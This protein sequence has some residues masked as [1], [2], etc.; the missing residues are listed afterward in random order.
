MND[1]LYRGILG[2]LETRFVYALT[3]DLANEAVLA[4]DCDPVSAHVLCRALTAGALTSPLLV[5]DERYTLRWQYGGALKSVVVDVDSRAQVRGFVAPSNLSDFAEVESAVYGDSGRVA[6]IKSSSAKVLSS[7]VVEAQLMDVVDDLAFLFSVSD[8]IETGMAVLVG[9]RRDTARPVSVCQG[10][11][12]QA[13]PECDLECF[14]GVRRR[15]MS[16]ACRGLL[17]HTP[18]TDNHFEL[19]ARSLVAAGVPDAKLALVTGGDPCFR[20]TCSRVRM[21]GAVRTLPEADLRETAAKGEDVTMR[22]HFCSKSHIITAAE[23]VEA[24]KRKT[25][26]DERQG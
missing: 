21:L 17:S 1:H 3:T 5:G 22:C 6:A 19:V 9:F 13:L 18:G 10:V 23:L 11:M 15:L 2:G 25:E 16:S 14:D 8:Q 20:C 7:G 4:H 12:V 24:L 26:G